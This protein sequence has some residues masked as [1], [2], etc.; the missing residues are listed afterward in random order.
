MITHIPLM[1]VPFIL[2][3]LVL[4]GLF[5][6]GAGDPWSGALFS[7]PMLSGGLWTM[8]LG[9]LLI[10]VS[11]VILFIEILKATRTSNA[12]VV[13]HLLSAFVFVAFLVEFLLVPG[14]A[15]S[16]FF[17]LTVIALVDL[18]AGFSVSIR[19]ARRDVTFE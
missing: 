10:A 12:S 13:D 6:A 11:L 18:L 8:T 7:V 3:N 16:V 2:F 9:D 17:I 19:S 14:A 1:I 5:G 15:H 4:A